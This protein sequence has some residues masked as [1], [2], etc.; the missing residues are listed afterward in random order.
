MHRDPFSHARS[1][2]WTNRFTT[3]TETKNH[4]ARHVYLNDA[5]IDALKS[6]SPRIQDDRLFPFKPY[7]M[8]TSLQTRG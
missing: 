4:E 5:A 1:V 3:L 6:L 2:D 7:Q 8:T